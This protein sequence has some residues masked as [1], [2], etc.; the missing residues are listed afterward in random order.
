MFL[1]IP[2]AFLDRLTEYVASGNF[3]TLKE[4]KLFSVELQGVFSAKKAP[5]LYSEKTLLCNVKAIVTQRVDLGS[6]NKKM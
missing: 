4:Q 3:H 6:P 2:R 1:E 5:F